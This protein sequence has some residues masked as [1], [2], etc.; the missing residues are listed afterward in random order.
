LL[1]PVNLRSVRVTNDAEASEPKVRAMER[2][3][4]I[5]QIKHDLEILRTRYAG[6]QRLAR[7]VKPI[8]IALGLIFAIVV[9]ALAVK[10]FASDWLYGL[11]FVAALLIFTPALV[12]AIGDTGIRWIDLAAPRVRG[13][14]DP[15]FF[16]PDRA[17]WPTRSEAE[18]TEQQIADYERRLSELGGC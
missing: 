18:V 3:A 14:Y 4:E 15:D 9:L 2:E 6:Y 16:N 12:W 1:A 8:Y 5:L 7:I 17:R 13:I 10:I 11:F